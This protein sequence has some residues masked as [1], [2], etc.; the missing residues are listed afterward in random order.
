MK[1]KKLNTLKAI[2]IFLA[3][4]L[5]SP[6]LAFFLDFAD[7]LPDSLSKLLHLQ[8]L[9]AILS[10]MVALVVF[11]LL[12]TLFFGRVYCSVICPAGI[13]QDIFNRIACLGKKKKNGSLRFRYHKPANWVRYSI[14]GLTVLTAVFGFMELCWVLDPYSNFGRITTHLFRP[15]VIGVNNLISGILTA[16]GNYLLYNLTV[17]RSL[18]GLF[19][20]LIA[21][22]TLV[23]MVLFR[24]RWFCNTLCPAGALLSIVSRYSFFRVHIDPITCNACKT[25]ERVCKAEAIDSQNKKVDMSRC[26]A[27]YNCLSSCNRDAIGYGFVKWS[28]SRF[29]TSPFEVVSADRQGGKGMLMRAGVCENLRKQGGGRRAFLVTSASVAGTIP[30]LAWGQGRGR[31]MR[32]NHAMSNPMGMGHRRGHAMRN[33]LPVTPPGSVGLDR[34]KQFCTGCHLC[35]VQ[36]P[37]HVLKPAGFQYGLDFL[38]RPF[39]S[40]E[41]SY[42]NYSCTACSDVCP[43]HAIK[44]L[45]VEQKKVTQIGIAFLH[46]NKC[47]VVTDETDC[48]ACVEHCPMQAVHMIP[49]KRNLTIPTVKNELCI[50]CGACE[51][52]CPVRPQRAIVVLANAVHQTA[53]LPPEEEKRQVDAIDFGF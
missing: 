25:C 5:F 4:L 11:H 26:V 30:F 18:E 9:P 12:L 1:K 41:K 16:R 49:Y 21:F 43:T 7:V 17:D 42:C 50:G 37:T 46:I 27:C 13:L 52:I 10:G 31:M 24:G 53:E 2:R 39:M 19:L 3:V 29:L 47:V 6:A 48:G 38:L 34:Y 8:L 33:N 36:C 51:S 32:D 22:F 45:T 40:Y 20:A 14:L 44:P 15:V 35:V 23:V 28:Q